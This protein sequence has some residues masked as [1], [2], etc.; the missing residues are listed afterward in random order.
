MIAIK[1]YFQPVRCHPHRRSKRPWASGTGKVRRGQFDPFQSTTPSPE[2]KRGSLHCYPWSGKLP[3]AIYLW[4][5]SPS[6]VSNEILLQSVQGCSRPLERESDLRMVLQ[7][8]KK[9]HIHYHLPLR[10]TLFFPGL[11]AGWLEVLARRVTVAWFCR[12]R[13]SLRLLDDLSKTQSS[14]KSPAGPHHQGENLQQLG[15]DRLHRSGGGWWPGL[16]GC[17]ASLPSG[18]WWIKCEW[19][20]QGV[21][22]TG[23]P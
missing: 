3:L 20:I 4:L 13:E 14:E 19:Y 18:P 21:F 11:I 22:F 23:P 1:D 5:K 12:S 8:R 9:R 17:H 6:S 16:F 7:S 10:L 15:Q 2:I